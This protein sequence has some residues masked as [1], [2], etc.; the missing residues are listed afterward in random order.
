MYQFTSAERLSGQ[1]YEVNIYVMK[2]TFFDYTLE[3]LKNLVPDLRNY[4]FWKYKPD[5]HAKFLT[6][7]ESN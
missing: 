2:L 5:E 7:T 4:T 3:D 1:Y 6:N